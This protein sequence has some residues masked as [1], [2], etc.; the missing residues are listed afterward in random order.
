MAA[1]TPTPHTASVTMCSQEIMTQTH[2]ILLNQPIYA[3]CYVT[4]VVDTNI[5]STRLKGDCTIPDCFSLL[6]QNQVA[7]AASP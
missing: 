1:A 5:N 3:S 4:T 6:N 2:L 7:A